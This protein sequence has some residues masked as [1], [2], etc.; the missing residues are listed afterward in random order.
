MA[1]P[2]NQERFPPPLDPIHLQ[3]GRP[4]TPAADFRREPGE[5]VAPPSAQ[6]N[7]FKAWVRGSLELVISGMVFFLGPPALMIG[8]P[9]LFLFL[10]VCFFEFLVSAGA[11][12]FEAVLGF[13]P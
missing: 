2:R 12:V 1:S 13:S 5:R 6:R 8:F 9:V 4:G 10:I 7:R 11:A 3:I